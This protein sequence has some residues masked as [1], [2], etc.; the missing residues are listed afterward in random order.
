MAASC[1]A[2]LDVEPVQ[3]ADIC[4][5]TEKRKCVRCTIFWPPTS[6]CQELI[7]GDHQLVGVLGKLDELCVI[8]EYESSPHLI[9]RKLVFGNLQLSR[10]NPWQQVENPQLPRIVKT[11]TSV[12]ELQIWR[13]TAYSPDSQL[14]Y[15]LRTCMDN[16]QGYRWHVQ[17]PWRNFSAAFTF[18]GE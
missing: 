8:A 11:S 17:F 12:L 6:N 13:Y 3:A 18:P 5:S 2:A 1:Q 16:A 10:D 14:Q 9:N 4:E 15:L 7:V